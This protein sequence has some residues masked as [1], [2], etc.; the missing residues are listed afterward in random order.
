MR[1]LHNEQKANALCYSW[2]FFFSGGEKLEK[3]VFW[4]FFY[5]ARLFSSFSTPTLVT[6]YQ[7]LKKFTRTS[8]FLKKD[9][10][11]M[12]VFLMFVVSM[13]FGFVTS[14]YATKRGRDAFF[15]FWIGVFF[16][17]LGFLFLFLL[18]ALNKEGEDEENEGK[19][20]DEELLLVEKS[21]VSPCEYKEWYYF[22]EERQQQGPVTFVVLKKMWRE[23]LLLPA[24]YVWSEGLP[25]WEK[26]ENCLELKD[27]LEVIVERR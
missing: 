5:D 26:I 17:L 1:E 7:N 6:V 8:G 12:Q 10:D 14:Y 15:W 22:D 9:L 20:S 25:D 27:A 13:F 2:L 19:I 21:P 23:G 3:V 24:S 18:P 4:I 11:E 16:G